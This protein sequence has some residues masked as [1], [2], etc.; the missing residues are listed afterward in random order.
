MIRFIKIY[1]NER[2]I[3]YKMIPEE[4][5]GTVEYC[6]QTDEVHFYLNGAEYKSSD[7][8]IAF[9]HVL[10]ADFPEEFIYATH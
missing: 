5:Y 4:L 9:N 8:M 1:E 7:I 6:K 10:E 2:K 3:V